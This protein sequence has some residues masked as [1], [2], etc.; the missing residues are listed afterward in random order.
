MKYLRIVD[1]SIA[2]I[3]E[4]SLEAVWWIAVTPRQRHQVNTGTPLITQWVNI[5]E[6]SSKQQC[7]P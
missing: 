4:S 5:Y 2:T 3:Q 1:D 7:G 6:D